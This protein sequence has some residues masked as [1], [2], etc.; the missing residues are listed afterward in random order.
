MQQTITTTLPVMEAF[1]TLQ[2]E[3]FHQ[4]RAAYFIRLGGCDVGCF[5]CDVKESWDAAAHPQI[6]IDNI[7]AAAKQYPGRLAVITGGE[8]LMHDLAALT[9]ALHAEGFE[10]NIETSGSS[11]LSGDW[12]W[13]CLSPKK[14][15]A[16]LPGIVP[17]ANELKVVIYNKHD[18][19]WAETYAAQ[20]NPSCKLYLQP[21]WSK[22]EQVVP[23]LVDYIKENPQWELSLQLHKYI[24]VP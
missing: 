22:A 10:T 20:C 8:P 12:D 24:N 16:P 3:G 6:S 23:M 7:V 13:I 21:E 15:K 18:F 19:E 4:G 11:P 2:G 14:F 1:Y 5:W 17:R 9:A